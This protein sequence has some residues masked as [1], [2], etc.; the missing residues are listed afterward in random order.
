MLHSE[1]PPDFHDVSKIVR[2]MKSRS[3]PCSFDR[4]NVI[5]FKKCPILRTHLAKLLS[6]VCR[7]TNL[8]NAVW[9]RTTVSLIY[10]K[11]A[12]D[13]PNNFRPNAPQPIRGKIFN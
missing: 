10:K 6:A 3:S 4:I 7:A 9:K 5:I 8:R 2:A 1:L 13:D 12:L 11:G